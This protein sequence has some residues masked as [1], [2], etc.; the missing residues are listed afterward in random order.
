ARRGIS[1]AAVL[2]AL[3]V[4]GRGR[5]G[6][7]PAL[8]RK[9][10]GGATRLGAGLPGTGLSP[11]AAALA[12]GG[13]STKLP[14]QL[15]RATA[16]LLVLCALGTGLGVFARLDTKLAAPPMPRKPIEGTV[17]YRGRVLDLDGKP[18]PR[19]RVHLWDSNPCD[20]RARVRAT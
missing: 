17:E 13:T 20:L 16:L 7:P 10:T 8:A 3:A 5:A 18:V 9:A 6:G 14:K 12:K 4:A 11:R 19:A 2:T 15:K 1:L